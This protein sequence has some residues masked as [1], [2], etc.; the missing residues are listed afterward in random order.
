LLL[1]HTAENPQANYDQSRGAV[2]ALAP[3]LVPKAENAAED[4][5]L[6]QTAFVPWPQKDDQNSPDM[7]IEK[8]SKLFERPEIQAYLASNAIAIQQLKNGAAKARCNWNLN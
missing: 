8:D 3:P 1:R 6:A 7:I 5:K 4:Y 2:L